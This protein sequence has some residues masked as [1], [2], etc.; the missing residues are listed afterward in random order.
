MSKLLDDLINEVEPTEN[1]EEAVASLMVGIAN[2]IEACNGD[3][4]RLSDLKTVLREDPTRVSKAVLA[5]TPAAKEKVRTT[6]YDAPSTAFELPREDV[7]QGDIRSDDKRDQVF[8][9]T[10]KTE[11]ERER[12]KREQTAKDRGQAVLVDERS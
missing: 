9:E 10:D 6:G 4:V 12:M 1:A 8:P 3:K 5:N 7:R 2:R 11:E